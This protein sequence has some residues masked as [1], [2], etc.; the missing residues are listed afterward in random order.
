MKS[1]IIL[2]C[3]GFLITIV[4]CRSADS[5][6]SAVPANENSSS[7]LGSILKMKLGP[8]PIAEENESQTLIL[9][10]EQPG[11]HVKKNYKFIVVRK[12]D[13]SIIHEGSYQMGYVKWNDDS[14]L[15]LTS[16]GADDRPEKKFINLNIN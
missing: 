8:D 2:F 9:Y 10:K 5:Q 1:S 11:G 3:F 6:K 15:E 4:S 7:D 13:N 12:S 16:A 14:S